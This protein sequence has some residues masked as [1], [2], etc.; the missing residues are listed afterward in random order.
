M[1]VLQWLQGGKV[2]Q[3]QIQ[4]GWQPASLF[5]KKGQEQGVIVQYLQL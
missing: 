2:R 5:L 1:W 3:E 4:T